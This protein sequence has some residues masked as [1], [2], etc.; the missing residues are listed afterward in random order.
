MYHI[1]RAILQDHDRVPAHAKDQP[2]IPRLTELHRQLGLSVL[3]LKKHVQV[4]GQLREC[5][6]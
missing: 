5:F 2:T 1:A 4:L 6:G 3:G